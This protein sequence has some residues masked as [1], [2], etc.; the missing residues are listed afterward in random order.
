MQR[1]IAQH[2][3]PA[4]FDAHKYLVARERYWRRVQLWHAARLACGEDQFRA[5]WP[6]IAVAVAEQLEREGLG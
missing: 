4:T 2:E 3:C 6:Q 5:S 1:S